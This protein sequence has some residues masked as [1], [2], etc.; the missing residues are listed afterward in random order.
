VTT[1]AK[2]DHDVVL[3][4]ECRSLDAAQKSYTYLRRLI[5]S[6]QGATD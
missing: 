4:V 5:E 1:L 2:A 3:S 6:V